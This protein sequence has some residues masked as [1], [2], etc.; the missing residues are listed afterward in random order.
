MTCALTPNASFAPAPAQHVPLERRLL[1]P[2][3][4]SPPTDDPAEASGSSPNDGQQEALAIKR[5]RPSG[6]S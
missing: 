6:A 4:P 1:A 5:L 2:E 3:A